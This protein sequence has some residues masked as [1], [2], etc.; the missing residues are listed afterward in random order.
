MALSRK[1]KM[2][3]PPL[4]LAILLLIVGIV[5]VNH[6]KHKEHSMGFFVMAFIIFIV[7]AGAFSFFAT[8]YSSNRTVFEFF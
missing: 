5:L 8:D 4:L 3:V 2:L 1:F 7:W 6:P